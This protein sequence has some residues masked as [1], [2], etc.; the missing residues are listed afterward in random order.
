MRN[1]KLGQTVAPTSDAKSPGD[2]VPYPLQLSSNYSNE[3]EGSGIGIAGSK[4]K[5]STCS[6]IGK[7]LSMSGKAG[8]HR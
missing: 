3:S 5:D 4:G 6:R 7:G 2:K 1:Q 8:G